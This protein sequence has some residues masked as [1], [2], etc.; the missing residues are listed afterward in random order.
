MKQRKTVYICSPL[1]GACEANIIRANLYSRYAYEQG[2]LPIA[3]HAIFTQF[4]DDHEPSERK[5][6][7]QMGLQLLEKCDELWAFGLRITEGMKQEI[8]AAKKLGIKTRL[9]N[10]DMEE[11]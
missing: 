5:A 6:G 3:P 4:L 7:M 1:R 8:E 11:Q 2:C 9:F 10:Q